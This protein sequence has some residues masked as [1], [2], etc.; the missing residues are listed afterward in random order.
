MRRFPLSPHSSTQTGFEYWDNVIAN[1][2][3]HYDGIRGHPTALAEGRAKGRKVVEL[4][5][6][7][8]ESGE[9]ETSSREETT[10]EHAT[11]T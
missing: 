6:E 4:L 2:L 10:P 8:Q 5:R 9:I 3:D 7:M 1:D 11:D